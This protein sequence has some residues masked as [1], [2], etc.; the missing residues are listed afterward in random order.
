MSEAIEKLGEELGVSESEREELLPSGRQARFANRIHWAR[1]YLKQA[2]LMETPRRGFF[3]IT[4]RGGEVLAESP[5]RIDLKFL[6]RFSEFVA[7][8]TLRHDSAAGDEKSDLTESAQ[9]PDEMMEAAYIRWRQAL[10]AE[11]LDAVMRCS[12]AFFERLVVDLLVRMGYGGSRKEAGQATRLSGD[13]GIDGII[14]EDRLGLDIIY[15]QAKRWQDNVGRP[16]VQKFVG[17]LH[18]QRANKGVFLTTSGFTPDAI[19]YAAAIS[20]KVILIDGPT[21]AGLMIDFGVGVATT[22]AFELKQIDSDY[23]TET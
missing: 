23:F 2:G 5:T 8:R 18:G 15:L 1:S 11:V 3:R 21:L 19:E 13:G 22:K 10:A 4:T 9:T 17:A 12:P 14:K 16:E 6:N 7:F 20:S